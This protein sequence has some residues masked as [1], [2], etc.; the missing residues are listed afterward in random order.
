MKKVGIKR[1]LF[2]AHKMKDELIYNMAKSEGSTLDFAETSCVIDGISV[3]GKRMEELHRIER[4]RDGWDEIIYQVKNNLF[5][6]SKE[7][8]IHINSI[9]AQTENEELGD[10][11]TKL[12]FIGGTRWQPPLPMLISEQF[13][14]LL[15][16]FKTRENIEDKVYNLF[17]DS[18]RT[19][20]FGDGNKRT[21]QLIMNGV[22]MEN[23]YSLFSIDES[24]DLEYKKKLVSFYETGDKQEM[25]T[26]MGKCHALIDS[27]FDFTDNEK[28]DK[29]LPNE[30]KLSD[31][32]LED[33]SEQTNTSK[34][35]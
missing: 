5:D 3:G 21:A 15:N 16:S 33:D 32:K 23:G 10:F 35:S 2:I 19:Q 1:S 13:N 6:V 26:F 29:N 14:L 27:R 7:N 24:L 9:V 8:F 4:L 25:L 28:L 34:L 22:L 12:V 31:T 11:R 18:A 20:A 17:L 30:A